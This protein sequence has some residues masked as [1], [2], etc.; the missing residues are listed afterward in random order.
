[1][2][3]ED[4]FLDCSV[5]G[6]PTKAEL[7][8]PS[9]GPHGAV[10]NGM[11]HPL[12][13]M[14]LSGFLWYQGEGNSAYPNGYSCLLPAM[15]ADWRAKW[16]LPDAIFMYVQLAGFEARGVGAS[17]LKSFWYDWAFIRAAMD[18]SLALPNVGRVTA[19][20]LGDPAS[21]YQPFHPR[22]KQEVGRRLSVMAM[23][24]LEP[25]VTHSSPP[26]GPVL[27]SV[28][29]PL[30]SPPCATSPDG[31]VVCTA[32]PRITFT[33]A[34]ARGLHFHGTLFCTSCCGSTDA[35]ILLPASASPLEAMQPDGTWARVDVRVDGTSLQVES[36]AAIWGLRLQWEGAPQCGLYNGLG[37]PADGTAIVAAP[38]Q[39]CQS[40]TLGGAGA[41]AASCQPCVPPECELGP[42]DFA[43]SLGAPGG[44]GSG[45]NK[46]A[47]TG[48][49]VGA[50]GG[51]ILLL[52]IPVLLLKHKTTK[53]KLPIK[54]TWYKGGR[55]TTK[56]EVV[57]VKPVTTAATKVGVVDVKPE[58]VTFDV[59][60]SMIKSI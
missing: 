39:W 59:D 28:L 58:V 23:G 6:H 12:L 10:Y 30:G 43:D 13:N 36:L 47:I 16:E 57:D 40:G 9:E 53:D 3:G 14:R 7:R 17:G 32:R 22:Y 5:G 1:M 56:V 34:T 55:G 18:A 37:G 26:E 25:G 49:A 19:I 29:D 31:Q 45:G 11:I 27:L 52:L 35:P 2:T 4:P 54:W 42:D 33:P 48:A 60:A 51:F 41:W 44:G 46:G 50:V 24:L 21:P 15:I 20:D 38:F 8:F